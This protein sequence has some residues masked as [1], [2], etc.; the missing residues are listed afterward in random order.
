[1]I[2]V[3]YSHSKVDAIYYSRYMARAT[4]MKIQYLSSLITN[5]PVTGQFTAAGPEWENVDGEYYLSEVNI[6]VQSGLV[7]CRWM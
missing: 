1:M 3:W 5:N 4:S 7:R 6:Q 2:G